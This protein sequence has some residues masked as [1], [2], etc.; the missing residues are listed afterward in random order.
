MPLELWGMAWV[1]PVTMTFGKLSF[2]MYLTHFA[3]FK[4]FAL[5]GFGALFPHTVLGSVLH[6]MCVVLV[7]TAASAVFYRVIEIPGMA[8]GKPA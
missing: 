8:L 2:S 1:N 4:F 6:F 7:A 3:V 5:I